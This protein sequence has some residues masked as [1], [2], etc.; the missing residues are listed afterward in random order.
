VLSRDL[1]RTSF[2]NWLRRMVKVHRADPVFR[3]TRMRVLPLENPRVLAFVREGEAGV[4]LCV[5]NL[6]RFAQ[7]AVLPLGDWTGRRPVDL[8]GGER[9]PVIDGPTYLFTLC[10]HS[11]LWLRLE[12]G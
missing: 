2:L 8:F 5:Y 6:S 9:F 10:P 7:P 3:G 11:I 4:V 1:K 12:S